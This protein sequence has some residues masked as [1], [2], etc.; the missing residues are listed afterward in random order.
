[1]LKKLSFE[2]ITR[3]EGVSSPENPSVGCAKAHLKALQEVDK[4]PFI[5]F[6]DDCVEKDFNPIIEVPDDSDA[7]FLGVSAC[8]FMNSHSGPYVQYKKVDNFPKLKRI[9]NML[10]GHSIL[11]ITKEYINMCK[12]VMDW[13]ANVSE[14]VQDPAVAEI[15]KY[16]N[17]FCFEYPMF[18]Q[19]SCEKDTKQNLS[20]YPT[21]PCLKINPYTFYPRKMFK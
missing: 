2:N 20:S 13:S 19:T 9:Y 10:S 3:V 1:M 11:Y 6:E 8:G 18:Y 17:V 12:R 21:V 15:Q 14:C 5:L 16:F 4:G 7:I